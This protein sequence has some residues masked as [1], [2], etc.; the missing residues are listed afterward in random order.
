[1]FYSLSP[2]L[3]KPMCQNGAN[4]LIRLCVNIL[5]Q[6]VSNSDHSKSSFC[7]WCSVNLLD[8]AS[9]AMY[10]YGKRDLRKCL[11]SERALL[12]HLI[13]LNLRFQIVSWITVFI[14]K[15]MNQVWTHLT[16]F[17]KSPLNTTYSSI[18]LQFFSHIFNESM[19]KIKINQNCFLIRFKPPNALSKSSFLMQQICNAWISLAERWKRKVYRI[20]LQ[21]SFCHLRGMSYI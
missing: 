2:I 11:K 15:W 7:V 20:Q 17:R 9:F 16:C 19:F 5:H 3:E 10:V 1:M 21:T 14:S 4:V 12:G 6:N 18:N 8:S 13:V